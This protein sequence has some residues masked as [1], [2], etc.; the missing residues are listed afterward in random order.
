MLNFIDISDQDDGM[1]QVD[2]DYLTSAKHHLEEDNVCIS[3]DTENGTEE[4]C[5]SIENAKKL[6]ALINDVIAKNQ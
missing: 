6:A 3:I 4:Y 1:R 5:F 2:V